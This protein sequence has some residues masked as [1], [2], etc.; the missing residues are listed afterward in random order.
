MATEQERAQELYGQ[1]K[2]EAQI[3]YIDH[4]LSRTPVDLQDEMREIVT[5]DLGSG[6]G[7][8]APPLTDSQVILNNGDDVAV[9]GDS[10]F[11][12][13]GS[14]ATA[15]VINGILQGVQLGPIAGARSGGQRQPMRDPRD[16]DPRARR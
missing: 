2:P 7:G 8:G 14:P 13:P 6:G 5:N 10:A 1:L 12:A 9:I 15:S 16:P 11:P 3:V 4:I